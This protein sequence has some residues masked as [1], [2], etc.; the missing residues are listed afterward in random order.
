MEKEILPNKIAVIGVGNTLRSDDGIGAHI[1]SKIDEL[2]LPFI[3]TIIV[4]QLHVELIEELINYDSVII[5]DAAVTGNDVDL[6]SLVFN[7]T[8]TTSSSHHMN[9]NMLNALLQKIHGKKIT[10]NLCSVR[11]ENFELGETLSPSAIAN[12]NKAVKIICDF[13][14]HNS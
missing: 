13:I 9:A 7:E 1:C 6:N 12:A 3:T 5:A 8:Q 2:N 11:G 4:Q 14:T 10:I